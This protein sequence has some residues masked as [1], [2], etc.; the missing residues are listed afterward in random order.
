VFL[1]LIFDFCSPICILCI[2]HF[3]SKNHF[4]EVEVNLRP[5]VSPP[6]CLGVRCPS[7]TCDQFVILFEIS[8][9]HLRLCYFVAPSLMRGRVC[10]LLYSCFW[11][12]TEQSLLSQS[13]V[14]LSHILLSHLRLP[15][16]G[17]PGP[18]IY[19]SQEQGGPVIPPGHWVP[20]LSPF[21][22]RR[23]VVEVF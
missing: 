17:G 12:M 18:H 4:V 11:T 5:T 13:P 23:A 10:N 7:G 22:I 20:F 3:S 14:E 15:Q 9:R 6:V 19:I 1:D 21:R 8:F 2:G 16:S